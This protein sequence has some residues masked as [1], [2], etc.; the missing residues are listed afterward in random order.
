VITEEEGGVAVV[1]VVKGGIVAF[2]VKAVVIVV[3]TVDPVFA[4]GPFR[5]TNITTVT[6]RTTSSI[7]VINPKRTNS[8]MRLSLHRIHIL[9]VTFLRRNAGKVPSVRLSNFS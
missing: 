4:I 1:A 2:V 8:N 5:F 7:T 6:T 3:A 9:A